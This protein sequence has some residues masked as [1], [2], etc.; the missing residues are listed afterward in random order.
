MFGIL[1][2]ACLCAC[3]GPSLAKPQPSDLVSV[4]SEIKDVVQSFDGPSQPLC[5]CRGLSC[6]CSSSI[7]VESEEQLIS[8]EVG[9]I[10][11]SSSAYIILKLN[12]EEKVGRY[13]YSTT[14]TDLT[15]MDVPQYE[16]FK[17]CT[18]MSH[19]EAV[20]SL[21]PTIHFC[22]QLELHQYTKLLPLD[23]RCFKFENNSFFEESSV[24]Q[25]NGVESVDNG[26]IE[27]NDN[28]EYTGNIKF[29]SNVKFNGNVDVIGNFEFNGNVEFN[30]HV[31]FIGNVEFNSNVEFNGDI[32]FIG[33][34]KFNGI[35]EFNG[36]IV[37]YHGNM[38]FNMP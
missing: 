10:E 27:F 33:N 16:M 28:I 13:F 7:W 25:P 17:I 14:A 38:E 12:G 37:E 11:S 22:V 30:G 6:T 26:N 34:A 35:V 24:D 31:K 18:E 36:K 20:L 32:E 21:P 1:L 23:F 29:M 5:D 3:A 19:F 9:V 8:F 2:L 4:F 15:C